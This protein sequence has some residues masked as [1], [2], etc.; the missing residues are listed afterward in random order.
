[1]LHACWYDNK[2]NW[3]QTKTKIDEKALPEAVLKTI[4]EEY[5]SY[6]IMI[7]TRFENPDTSGFE[8]FLDNETYGFAVQL[9][10]E[11]EIIKRKLSS[12][13]YRSIDDDGNVIEE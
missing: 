10:K 7:T 4:E 5:A 8:V 3:I 13:G 2:G 9:S 11:G 12:K 6:K 1:V